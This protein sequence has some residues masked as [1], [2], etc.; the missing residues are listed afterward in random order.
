MSPEKYI[1]PIESDKKVAGVG[2]ERQKK[3]TFQGRAR[4]ALTWQNATFAPLILRG[5]PFFL[6]G[7]RQKEIESKVDQAHRRETLGLFSGA[8]AR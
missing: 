5:S 4:L 3:K 1:T 6:P 8:L 2:G 7:S